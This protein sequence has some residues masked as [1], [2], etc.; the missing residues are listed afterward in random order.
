MRLLDSAKRLIRE[1]RKWDLAPLGAVLVAVLLMAGA[2]GFVVTAR[3]KKPDRQKMIRT[4]FAT[5]PGNRMPHDQ[6]RLVF[7]SRCDPT[8]DWQYQGRPIY[9]CSL[10]FRDKAFTACFTFD[11]HGVVA[12]SVELAKP[13]SV[14]YLVAWDENAKSLVIL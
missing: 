3:D 4:Y 7:V 1:L 11:Q 6:L 9:L 2:F 8:N 5:K 13:G 10:S 12:G 14:C